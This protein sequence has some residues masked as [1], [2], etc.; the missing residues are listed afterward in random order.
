MAFNNARRN[1]RNGILGSL[2]GGMVFGMM[3]QMMGMMDTVAAIVRGNSVV[4]GWLVHMAVSM[5]LGVAFGLLLAVVRFNPVFTGLAWGMLAWVAGAL[6]L[7]PVLL[8]TPGM[9]F[10]LDSPT[11]WF[12]L[13]GHMMYGLVAG[14]VVMV[15]ARRNGAAGNGKPAIGVQ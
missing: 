4:V 2:I 8:G 1:L 9:V 13:M 11:P 14:L 12:S 3:L 10:A 15:M 5:V 7:M 6:V